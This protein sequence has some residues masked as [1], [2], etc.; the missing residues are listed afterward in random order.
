MRC[1]LPLAFLVGCSAPVAVGP[2]SGG[3]APKPRLVA[4]S[5]GR[6][7]WA[8]PTPIPSGRPA[9]AS[10]RR[11]VWVATTAC[12]EPL[13]AGDG[14]DRPPPFDPSRC[15]GIVERVIVEGDVADDRVERVEDLTI[16]DVAV[17]LEK[18]LR[19]EE[20]DDVE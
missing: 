2:R 7:V 18:L 1:L 14:A 10:G 16:E 5:S 8:A 15:V 9:A 12:V 11:A 4:A 20:G 19:G 3:A 17:K 6:S 13:A